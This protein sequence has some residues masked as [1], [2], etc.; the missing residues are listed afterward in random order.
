MK[1]PIR[2]IRAIRFAQKFGFEISPEIKKLYKNKTVTDNF[3]QNL[4][5]PEMVTWE[6]NKILEN[7]ENLELGLNLL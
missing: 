5:N 6:L 1:S 7:E 2:L 3:M 4:K